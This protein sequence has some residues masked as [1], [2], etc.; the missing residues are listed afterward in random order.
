[1]KHFRDN[2]ELYEEEEEPEQ[3]KDDGNSL[4]HSLIHSFNFT[5]CI[6]NVHVH[7]E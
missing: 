4:T 3:D 2:P 7:V 1:M 5:C 6:D